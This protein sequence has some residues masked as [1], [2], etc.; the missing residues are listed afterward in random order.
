MMAD[1]LAPIWRDHR[2]NRRSVKMKSSHLAPLLANKRKCFKL[3][4]PGKISYSLNVHAQVN[5]FKACFYSW[6]CSVESSTGTERIWS[7]NI[8]HFSCPANCAQS[9]HTMATCGQNSGSKST[10]W[11]KL[12]HHTHIA[13]AIEFSLFRLL[14]SVC[15]I[16]TN[17]Y[18][19]AA[20]SM[21]KFSE[22][23]TTLW[24]DEIS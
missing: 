24:S 20:F 16:I 11:F 18:S 10:V 17:T 14:F 7:M 5:Q 12:G 6:K 19:D 3:K 21:R 22:R 4:T 15:L 8:C 2:C 1:H 13:K 23:F 9:P